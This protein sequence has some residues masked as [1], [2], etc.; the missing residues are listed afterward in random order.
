MIAAIFKRAGECQPACIIIDEADYLFARRSDNHSEGGTSIGCLLLAAMSRVIEEE[1]MHV[2]IIATTML[3]ESFDEGLLRRFFCCVYVGLPDQGAILAIL[4]QKLAAYEL[5]DDVTD[6]RLH[7][8][9][10][11]VANRRTLSGYDVTRALEIELE[12]L[13]MKSWNVSKYFRE[14]SIRHWVSR[15]MQMTGLG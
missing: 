1:D 13:L 8:L 4:K 7:N 14:V 10:T 3:P 9:A 11:E 2:M 15:P 6:E 12:R 5:A